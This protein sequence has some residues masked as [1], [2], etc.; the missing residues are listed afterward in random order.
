MKTLKTKKLQVLASEEASSQISASA[1]EAGLSLS[2][3]MLMCSTSAKNLNEN[4]EI[5]ALEELAKAAGR[6]I[7]CKVKKPENRMIPGVHTIPDFFF[8]E[9]EEAYKI[10]QQLKKERGTK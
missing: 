1:K 7:H 6:V 9:L 8:D 3:Y 4:P 5:L 2:S 10:V